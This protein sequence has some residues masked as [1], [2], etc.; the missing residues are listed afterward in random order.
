MNHSL[1]EFKATKKELKAQIKETKRLLRSLE[2]E[3]ERET[4]QAQHKEV[5]H[6][7]EIVEESRPRLGVIGEFTGSAVKELSSSMRNLLDMIKPHHHDEKDE[8]DQNK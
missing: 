6:L 5:D 2:R 8:K 3:L 4:R 1:K 7:E